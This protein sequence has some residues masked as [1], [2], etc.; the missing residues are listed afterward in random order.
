MPAAE[1]DRL[2]IALGLKLNDLP[3]PVMALRLE[4][5]ELTEA[6]GQQL[7]LVKTQGAEPRR[8]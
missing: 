5:S 3:A 6:T 7:E 4:L 8:G 1:P 2:R